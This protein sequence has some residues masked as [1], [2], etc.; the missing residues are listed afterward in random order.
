MMLLESVKQHLTKQVVVDIDARFINE[1]LV[2]FVERNVK[3]FPGKSAL[4][5]NLT[6]SK[7]SH[8]ISLYTMENG[9]EMNDEMAAFLESRPEIEVQIVTA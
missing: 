6:E 5:F 4:R 1:S 9:F 7:S 3:K 8:K 2:Q